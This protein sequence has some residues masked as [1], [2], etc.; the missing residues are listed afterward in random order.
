MS[1]TT[2]PSFKKRL[3]KFLSRFKLDSHHQIE[4]FGAGFFTI[5]IAG[6]LILSAAG[7]TAF[8]NNR[9]QLG[10]TAIYTA[11]FTTSKT[12][13]SGTVEGLY[14]SEDK[15]RAM[16]LMKFDDVAQVSTNAENY[17]AFMT[18]I[19]MN[20][21]SEDLKGSPSGDIFVFGS[22]G[23]MGVLLENP[24]GFDTQIINLTLR[25]NEE[26]V[27]PEENTELDEDVAA[28]ESFA[29]FDQWRVLINPGASETVESKALTGNESDM[30]ELY[31]EMIIEPQEREL[32]AT[33][34]SQL[35]TL[36][37]DINAIESYTERLTTTK[38]DDTTL[39]APEV[40]EQ[41]AGDEILCDG[42][43]L[44]GVTGDDAVCASEDLELSTDW[45][46]PNG[47]DFDW[48]S[49]SVEE[50]YL[51]DLVPEGQTPLGYLSQHRAEQSDSLSVNEIE[52]TLADGTPLSENVAYQDSD[53]SREV[54]SNIAL[55]TGAYTTYYDHKKEYMVGSYDELLNLEVDLRDVEANYS[56]NTSDESVLVY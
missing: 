15:T 5:V 18:G 12:A 43:S 2:A 25:A 40:P 51:E 37:T 20:F 53:L 36:R 28:D 22:T 33:M 39:Q 3:N 23:Y 26:L 41:I 56:E 34:D 6:V 24:E 10:S 19:N 27:R 45:V 30:R 13:V 31:S 46:F 47:Y 49:G 52:W 54:N 21:G 14:T 35:E 50:G 8:Q 16:V 29:D 48:R 17:Q 11:G 38:F 1:E 9:A 7:V 44:K 32:R 4:R 55:L 42:R